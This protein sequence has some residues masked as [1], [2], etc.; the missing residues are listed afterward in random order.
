VFWEATNQKKKKGY[1]DVLNKCL[2]NN[3]FKRN[4]KNEKKTAQP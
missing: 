4:L 3:F 2:V 1:F